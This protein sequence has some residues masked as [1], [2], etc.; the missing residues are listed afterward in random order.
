MNVNGMFRMKQRRRREA[1][2]NNRDRK[3]KACSLSREKAQPIKNR[4]GKK[5]F[6]C[7]VSFVIG[8]SCVIVLVD[9]EARGTA[10]RGY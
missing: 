8:V 3:R 10:E 9:S 2:V 7:G 4:K 6:G 5:R 1:H